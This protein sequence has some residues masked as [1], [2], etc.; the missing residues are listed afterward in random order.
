METFSLSIIIFYLLFNSIS[1]FSQFDWQLEASMSGERCSKVTYS[2]LHT[3]GCV[4]VYEGM[5][6]ERND[7]LSPPDNLEVVRF[8]VKFLAEGYV[9]QDEIVK[10]SCLNKEAL[11]KIHQLVR[12]GGIFFIED[13][14]VLNHETGVIMRPEGFNLKLAY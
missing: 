3:Y 14:H 7:T 13:I 6:K 9:L 5:V 11:D 10:G 1:L 2:F 8:T 12:P 4:T